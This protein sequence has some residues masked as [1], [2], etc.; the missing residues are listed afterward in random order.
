M[1][2]P[3]SSTQLIFVQLAQVLDAQERILSGPGHQSSTFD[4]TLS[5]ELNLHL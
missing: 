5:N 2:E 4:S 1:D 3:E